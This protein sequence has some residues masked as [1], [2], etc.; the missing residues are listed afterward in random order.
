[1]NEKWSDAAWRAAQPTYEA[2]THLPFVTE[3]A[4]GTLPM[5]K[6][7]FYLQQDAIYIANYCK[8]LASIASRVDSLELTSA[9]LDFARDGVFVEK[10][11]HETYLTK[12]EVTGAVKPSPSCLLYMSL[13]SAQT[14]EPV[15]V[16]AASILPCFWVYLKVGMHIAAT[17][18]KENPFA[19][20]IATY[21]DPAFEVSNQ[22]AIDICDSLAEKA[23]PEIRRRMTEIFVAATKM[24]WLF[25]ESTY[26]LE[27]WKI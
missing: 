5:E 1:M 17:A 6:F 9:F 20:W 23:S 13:L 19:A 27:Q 24:E 18:A 3:L 15:E 2:I 21:S 11:M 14:T 26:N 4:A 16:Q 22:H 12:A 7:I 25:W 10:A 8:V